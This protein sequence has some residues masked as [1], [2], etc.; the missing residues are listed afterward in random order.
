MKAK[1][2]WPEEIY[3]QSGEDGLVITK[4]GSYHT[5]FVEAFIGKY[6]EE[7]LDVKLTGDL[8][9]R[10]EGGTIEQAEENAWNK[11]T[12]KILNNF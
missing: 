11:M 7:I 8:F 9:I 5:A 1:L 4:T 12:L 2:E 10:G 3:L 6:D